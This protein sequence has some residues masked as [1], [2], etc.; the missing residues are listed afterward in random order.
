M[1]IFRECADIRP[2]RCRWDKFQGTWQSNLNF[3]VLFSYKKW[4]NRSQVI[5]RWTKYVKKS[6]R[7]LRHVT[8][9]R[10][11]SRCSESPA[12]RSGRSRRGTKTMG[13]TLIFL[14]IVSQDQPAQRLRSSE[15][16]RLDQIQKQWA[17]EGR[18][19]LD[20]PAVAREGSPD[21]PQQEREKA[22]HILM[23][24]L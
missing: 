23:V 12:A 4:P 20:S 18:P 21:Q 22:D 24:Q 13:R 7:W 15:R 6:L 17:R 1:Y 11:L 16:G 5:P 14:A 10:T 3:A 9:P 19:D 8:A 2:V